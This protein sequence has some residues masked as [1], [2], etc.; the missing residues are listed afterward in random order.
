[1]ALIQEISEFF[2]KRKS[3]KCENTGAAGAGLGN[4]SQSDFK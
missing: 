4:G 2:T 3:K 1:M